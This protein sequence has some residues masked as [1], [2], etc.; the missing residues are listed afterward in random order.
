MKKEYMAKTITINDISRDLRNLGLSAGDTVLVHSSLSS[1]GF[2]EGGPETVIDALLETVGPQ[3]TLLMPSFQS[4]GEHFLLRQGCVFDV[5][6]SPSELG[7]ITE[8]FRLR[9]GVI[10]SLNPTHCTAGIG[11]KASDI[12]KDHQYCT[13][14][15]G[16]NSPYDKLTKMN[17][18]ILLLGVTHD[19]DTTLHF[20]EN[21]GG[22]PTL[23]LEKFQPI[24]IDGD[25]R[26]WVVPM[27]PHMP[28]LKRKYGV[29]ED[30]LLKAGI[31]RN[32]PV[33]ATT[34][35]LIDAGKMADLVGEEIRKNPVFLID[36]FTP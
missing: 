33:G 16:K 9:P 12:L 31:Q 5:R 4:G 25:G 35:R 8:K 14:S 22:A 15:V 6:T 13:V 29:V 7:I 34:G 18:K 36:I 19:S 23:S 10:R 30:L 26:C 21:T 24:V 28:G 11:P 17:G 20:I 27:Y 3:G 2:V 1:L 32:S